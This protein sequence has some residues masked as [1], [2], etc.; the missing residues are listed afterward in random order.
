MAEHKTLVAALAAFH[1]EAPKVIKDATAK[2][3]GESKDGGRIS[4]TYGYA[5]LATVTEALNPVLGAHGLAF[6]S[7]PTMTPEGFGLAYALKHEGGESDEG[8]WPLPDPTRLKPQDLGSWIT[9]W[10]RYAFLAV[11]NTF[12]SGEDDDGGKASSRETWDSAQPRT[13]QAPEQPAPPAKTSWTDDEISEYHRRIEDAS[14]ELAKAV[15]GYDWMASKGLH[16]RPITIPGT[17]AAPITANASEILAY[18]MSDEAVRPDID[19]RG[20][21]FIRVYAEDRGL[22]K[23]Q[24]SETETLD[25]VLTEAEGRI[26]RGAAKQADEPLAAERQAG[27]LP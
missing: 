2:V 16:H 18:R 8:F 14:V 12:P 25:Q 27:D 23:V 5:D 3:T 17:D 13:Q 24:V 22:L 9:Y 4:Y 10:R 21:A 6:T 11:T 19:L 26:K 7:K 20:L 15:N 1:A